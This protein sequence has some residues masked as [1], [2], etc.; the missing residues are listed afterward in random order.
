MNPRSFVKKQFL[1]LLNDLAHGGRG[2]IAAEDLLVFITLA[3]KGFGSELAHAFA[4]EGFHD[5]IIRCRIKRLDDAPFVADVFAGGFIDSGVGFGGFPFDAAVDL[6]ILV[7]AQVIEVL[8]DRFEIVG[9]GV[10]TG[11]DGL[12]FER[13]FAP[14]GRNFAGND[15]LEVVAHVDLVDDPEA[16]GLDHHPH[17]TAIGPTADDHDSGLRGVEIEFVG[18][19]LVADRDAAVGWLGGVDFVRG[20]VEQHFAA[21]IGDFNGASTADGDRWGFGDDRD[22]H[23]DLGIDEGGGSEEGSFGAGVLGF[24]FG[25][26]LVEI[27]GFE[28]GGGAGG[29][30]RFA[31]RADRR[32]RQR[33][34]G[35]GGLHQCPEGRGLGRGNRGGLGWLGGAG[36]IEM[37]SDRGENTEDRQGEPRSGSGPTTDRAG[38]LPQPLEGGGAIAFCRGLGQGSEVSF[39]DR[40]RLREF[41]GFGAWGGFCFELAIVHG[42][43]RAEKVHQMPCLI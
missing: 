10:G 20:E 14:V 12:G 8:F 31:V 26:E 13:F 29:G 36:T 43:C 32:L 19:G 15:A 33:L 17:P 38:A 2:V 4:L 11:G 23:F 16:V 40:D 5:N 27:D 41:R 24:L 30:N 18:E 7:I 22:E 35:G 39:G 9:E 28:A 6:V 1:K 25:G 37:P 42:L 21:G 34:P 3:G